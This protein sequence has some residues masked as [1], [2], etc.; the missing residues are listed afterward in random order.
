MKTGNGNVVEELLPLVLT[1]PEAGKALRIGKN[2]A[3]ELVRCGKLRCIRVGRAIKIP[4]SA[5]YDF[6]NAA[7]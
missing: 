4:R 7:N 5:I 1:V 6:L 3:Y 2:S